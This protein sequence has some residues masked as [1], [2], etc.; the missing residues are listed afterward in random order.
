VTSET[1]KFFLL[2]ITKF[3]PVPKIE[4]PEMTI[5]LVN[6]LWGEEIMETNPCGMHGCDNPRDNAGNGSYHTLCSR[7][8]KEKYKMKG[9]DYRQYRT[10]VPYCENID[11][12][13][14]FICSAIIVNEC[15]LTVDHIDGN[16]TNHPPHGPIENLQTL[17]F[18]CHV[19]KTKINGDNLMKKY[20]PND[21]QKKYKWL[22]FVENLDKNTAPVSNDK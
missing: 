16:N 2:N 14:G 4:T 1:Q 19:V 21:E 20:R 5:E 11:G 17:C 8:H 6:T 12:R 22:K 7:H 15:Q 3:F 18:N 9:W 10:E 13:L